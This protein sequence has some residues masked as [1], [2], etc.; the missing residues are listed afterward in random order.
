[1]ISLNQFK[2]CSLAFFDRHGGQGRAPYADRNI[3]FGVGD[4]EEVVRK[5][6]ESVQEALGID[7]LVSARQ[8][9]GDKI[10]CYTGESLENGEIEGVDAL[11]TQKRGVGLMIQQADCQAVL[12]HDPVKHAIAAVHCGWRG[13]VNGIIGKTVARMRDDF[14]SNPADLLAA[15]SPSLGP[16]CGEFINWEKEL[17]GQFSKFQVGDSH[18]DFWRITKMQLQ[19]SGLKESA[20]TIAG[21]C[22]VCSRDYFSY[23]RSRRK[24]GGFTGRNCSVI[25][26]DKK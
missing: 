3:S 12:F 16:C 23:R 21:I 6:R 13:S 11:L 9:H 20:V 2:G 5:N 25:A 1:M 18:F 22:T 14:G 26:L 17:P 7:F 4:D 19:E 10:F 8:V 15:V 24:N